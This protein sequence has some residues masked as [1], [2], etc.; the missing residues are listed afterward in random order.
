[1]GST[2]GKQNGV[3]WGIT[4]GSKMGKY[5]REPQWGSKMGSKKGK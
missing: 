1:M 5:N 3:K 4:M 2:L